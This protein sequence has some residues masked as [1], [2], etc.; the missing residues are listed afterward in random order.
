M[1][2]IEVIEKIIKDRFPRIASEFNFK[3]KK[4]SYFKYKGKYIMKVTFSK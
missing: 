4:Y 2:K 3:I 1:N